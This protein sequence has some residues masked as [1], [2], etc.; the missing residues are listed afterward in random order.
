MDFSVLCYMALRCS[1]FSCIFSSAQFQFS[2]S[3]VWNYIQMLYGDLHGKEIQKRGDIWKHV[4]DSVW[5]PGGE[6]IHVHVWLKPLAAHQKL[7]QPFLGRGRRES[8]LMF[9]TVHVI[10]VHIYIYFLSIHKYFSFSEVLKNWL[11]FNLQKIP[12]LHDRRIS[13]T[14]LNWFIPKAFPQTSQIPGGSD[15]QESACNAGDPGSIPG[16]GRSP[17]GGHGNPL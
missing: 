10:I 5:Q 3:V 4:A 7:S 6:W 15:S 8:S 2:R 17:G 9:I 16:L 1:D 11:T 14:S 13:P 12:T